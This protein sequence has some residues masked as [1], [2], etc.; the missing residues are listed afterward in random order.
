M[1]DAQPFVG[2]PDLEA[3]EQCRL[4]ATTHGNPV[5]SL[6]QGLPDLQLGYDLSTFAFRS[7]SCFIAGVHLRSLFLRPGLVLVWSAYFWLIFK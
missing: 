6:L 5:E 2:V 4:E 7:L 1:L 3:D